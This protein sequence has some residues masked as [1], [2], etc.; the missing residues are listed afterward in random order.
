MK[1]C[2]DFPHANQETNNVVE[3]YH[4]Y[5]KTI[6]LCDRRKKCARRMDWLF[7]MLLTSVEPCYWFKEILKKE[8]YLNNYKKEK[9]FESLV[10]KARKILDDD[11]CPHES[12]PQS[13]WVRSQSIPTNKYLFNWYSA[14]FTV[15][16]C[17]WSIRGNICKN[18]IKVNWLYLNSSNSEPLC[19]QDAMDNTFNELPDISV[20]PHN[21]SVDVITNLMATNTIDAD[22]EA[23]YFARE[24]LFIYLQLIQNSLPT[25]LTK[26]K[27]LTDM[28]KK[29]LEDANTRNT[30]WILNSQSRWM[31]IYVFEEEEE[32]SKP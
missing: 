30:L 23:L 6:F 22:A 14:D 3:S 26:M 13:Y 8:G 7:Y 25:T 15:C 27:K 17:P 12:I 29:I 16:E 4:C 18:A 1:G 2:R 11:C 31:L 20:E 28:V 10:E 32:F 9:Q 5:L 19:H 21:H 24:E